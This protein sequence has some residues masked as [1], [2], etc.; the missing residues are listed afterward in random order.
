[1][2]LGGLALP[3]STVPSALQSPP[4]V[5]P[6]PTLSVIGIEVLN[7]AEQ[8]VGQLIPAGV[9][10]MVPLA[11]AETERVTVVHADDGIVVVVVLVVGMI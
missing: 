2:Q 6:A 7:I 10:V 3:P 9:L 8:V 1:M 4:R 11:H 5:S